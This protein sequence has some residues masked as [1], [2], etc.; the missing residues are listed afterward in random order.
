MPEIV[1][2]AVTA[3][4]LALASQTVMVGAADAVGVD[5]IAAGTRLSSQNND[6]SIANL[7]AVPPRALEAAL[8]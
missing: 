7:E 2:V 4:N 8:T 3:G 6:S 5:A 1:L